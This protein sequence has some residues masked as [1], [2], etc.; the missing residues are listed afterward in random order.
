MSPTSKAQTGGGLTLIELLVVI[1]IICLLSALVLSGASR[2]SEKAR[3]V[4]CQNQLRQFYAIAV[5]YTDEHDGL[6]GSYWDFFKQTPMLCPSDNT[7]GTLYQS[8]NAPPSS[9]FPSP[10]VFGDGKR[11]A[12]LPRDSW[13]LHENHPWHDHSKAPG[14]EPGKWKGRFL[15]LNVDGTTPWVLLE[16]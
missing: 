11:L 7:F 16:Q 2:S 12:D 13:M 14:F 5:A 4:K 3:R 8:T 9:Y 6:L 10:F 1:A 15:M